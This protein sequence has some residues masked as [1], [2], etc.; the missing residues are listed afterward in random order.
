M[1]G[2]S[3]Y[4]FDNDAFEAGQRFD[5]LSALFNPTTFRHIEALG[6]RHGW[7]CWEIGAGGPT[8]PNWLVEQVGP[9]GYVLATDINTSW[10]NR[11]L[12]AQVE[13]QQH[14]VTQDD[15]PNST[16]DLV[17]ARLVLSHLPARDEA[18][19]RMAASVRPGGWLLVEDFDNVM[20]I[21]CIDAHRPE[22]QRANKLHAAIRTLLA[23]RGADLE[24]ARKL[25]RIFDEIGLAHVSADAYFPVAMPAGNILSI[26]NI[27][28]VREALTAQQLATNEEIDAHLHT[29]T[30][31]AI[32]VGTMPLISTWGQR[33]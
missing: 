10:V 30:N 8:V 22:H 27:T 4:L 6:I 29:I 3:E 20:P 11:Q 26:A 2:I 32:A 17:H 7:R 16:F 28:Q 15:T 25:P 14:D 19:K 23:Q 33:N 12:S 5:A 9:S 24:Y 21:N 31:G 13:V 1:S 18:L